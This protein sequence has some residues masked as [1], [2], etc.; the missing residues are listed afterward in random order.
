MFSLEFGCSLGLHLRHQHGEGIASWLG[1]P[2]A[3]FA[4]LC[5]STLMCYL[6]RQ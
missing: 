5:T 2:L 6:W 4:G 3:V 1:E